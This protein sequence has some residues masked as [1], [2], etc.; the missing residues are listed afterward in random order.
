MVRILKDR[1]IV[2]NEEIKQI[3]VKQGAKASGA[4]GEGRAADSW[5]MHIAISFGIDMRSRSSRTR[6]TWMGAERTWSG[7]YT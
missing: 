1:G 6:K 2:E 7:G 4:T 5:A 3:D